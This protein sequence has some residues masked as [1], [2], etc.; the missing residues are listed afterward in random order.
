MI[1]NQQQSAAGFREGMS[2]KLM[3][4]TTQLTPEMADKKKNMDKALHYIEEAS[5]KGAEIIVFPELYLTGYTCG[6]KEGLFFELAETVP[7]ETTGILLKAAKQ[8]DIHIVIGMPELHR[9]YPA[10]MYNSAVFLS[11]DG[12]IQV[13]RKVHNSLCPPARE[14]RYGFTPG[15]DYHVFKIKQ[16][17]N[18]GMLICFD[19]WF[20]EAPRLLS[21]QGADVLMTISAGPSKYREDWIMVNRVRAIENTF[22]HVYSNILGTEWGDVS[23]PGDAMIISPTGKIIE[24]GPDNEE[25]MICA[26]LDSAELYS[27]RRTMS[28]LRNRRPFT[29]G[30]L[31]SSDTYPHI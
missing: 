18:I 9:E 3:V 2:S 30:Q 7:G 6:E 1:D 24:K 20:P 21:V 25:A 22:F 14:L 23:F 12:T 26:E 16:N 27:A 17:W 15:N 31:S 19:T 10:V 5:G 11:P 29:Y 13:H 28:M 8:H 4:A